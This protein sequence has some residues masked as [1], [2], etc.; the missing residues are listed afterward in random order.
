MGSACAVY[1]LSVGLRLYHRTIRRK[2]RGLELLRV[3]QTSTQFF[4]P[5]LPLNTA[6][7][8]VAFLEAGVGYWM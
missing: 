3:D 2:I 4:I 7:L 1:L 8:Y 5:D 6:Y